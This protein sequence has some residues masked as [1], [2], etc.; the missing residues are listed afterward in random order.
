MIYW[1][2]QTINSSMRNYYEYHQNPWILGPGE[3]VTV[4][5]GMGAFVNQGPTEGL[6]KKPS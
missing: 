2:T 5:C 6:L 1:V 4:P 3:Q